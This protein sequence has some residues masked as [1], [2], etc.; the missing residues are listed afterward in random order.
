MQ[1]RSHGSLTNSSGGT[2]TSGSQGQAGGP[3]SWTTA[4]WGFLADADG[5]SISIGGTSFVFSRSL[6]PKKRD[7]EFY[8]MVGDPKEIIKE[9]HQVSGFP[10]LFPKF[11]F[12]FLN[13]EWG[14]TKQNCTAIFR[15]TGRNQFRSTHIFLI[16]IGWI[17][18]VTTTAN[19]GGDQNF[20]T[21]NPGQ[22]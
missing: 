22:S 17:G 10:P 20:P 5:G 11:T 7:L 3:F 1:N 6:S 9:L 13:S 15:R 12:G 14:S 8:L 2:I 4:G 16:S 21:A 18:G 19:S